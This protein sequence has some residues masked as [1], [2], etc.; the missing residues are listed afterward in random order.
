MKRSG[1]I[2][3]SILIGIMLGGFPLYGE[4]F[5]FLGLPLPS[6][7]REGAYTVY[8]FKAPE[9]VD[10]TIRIKG[11]ELSNQARERLKGLFSLYSQFTML[12]IASLRLSVEVD[13]IEIILLPR[14]FVYKG[15]DLS[16]YMPS[17]MQFTYSDYLEFD[18]R[19]VVENLFVRIKGQYFQEPEFAEKI[20]QAVENPY[21]YIQSQD[22][23]YILRRFQEIEL[24]LD[25]VMGEGIKLGD[26]LKAQLQEI[27]VQIASLKQEVSAYQTQV[28]SQF[29]QFQTQQKE[30]QQKVETLTS[31][32]QLLRYALLVLNNRGF[33]GSIRLPSE[34][35]ISRLVELKQQQPK[36]T[37]DEARERLKS[38]GIEMTSKEVF[39]VFSVY[40][41]EFT[42]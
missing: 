6:Q 39:L 3:L 15:R 18:F 31:E 30:L 21:L 32:F 10:I 37:M 38:E 12:K 25:R 20:S 40:F 17:G 24:R 35:G 7:A 22:P 2:I 11:T 28:G 26:T 4:D 8:R 9:E 5:S 29:T 36:L 1:G 19:I 16:T 27:Q 42:K 41:N 14:S 34:A 23:E 33:F 13:Q